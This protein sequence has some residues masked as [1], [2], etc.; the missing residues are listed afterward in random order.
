MS[1][2]ADEGN[3][4]DEDEASSSPADWA[5]SWL[6]LVLRG[7]DLISIW[8]IVHVELRERIVRELLG[9]LGVAG[10]TGPEILADLL[11]LDFEA[12]EAWEHFAPIMLSTLRGALPPGIGDA[13]SIV[14]V[15]DPVALDAQTLVFDCWQLP[16][17]RTV[18]V[19]D[20]LGFGVTVKHN[21]DLDVWQVVGLFP[22]YF[23]PQWLVDTLTE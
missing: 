4:V 8:R 16:G 5:G 11:R 17:T 23:A 1:N 2:I 18:R 21:A 7:D 14:S 20:R 15:V 9:D 19:G 22:D 12:S 6:D 10:E 3:I 13:L